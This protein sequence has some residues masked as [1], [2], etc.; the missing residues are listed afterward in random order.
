MT[1]EISPHSLAR[2]ARTQDYERFLAIQRAPAAKREA[3]YAITLLNAELARIGETVTEPMIRAIRFAWWREALEEL[4]A[5][6]HPRAHPILQVLSISCARQ[7]GLL[8]HLLSMC[9]ARG[10]W[11]EE[12]PAGA[13]RWHRYI[14]QTAGALH[15]AWA[16]LLSQQNPSPQ[17]RAI[18]LRAA[19][20][21]AVI[22]QL[23]SIPRACAAGYTPYPEGLMEGGGPAQLAE[24]G[25]L[26]DW[27]CRELKGLEM[28][29]MPGEAWQPLQV[30]ERISRLH[31]R[32]ILAANGN[33]Y[34]L[35][36]PR[37]RAV[38]CC[39]L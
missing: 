7:P 17:C 16:E 22:G 26:A 4:A 5:G 6:G 27:A 33:V 24:S 35:K 31:A 23:R 34:R 19:H 9:R 37:I 8:I 29:N 32:R 30:L 2:E 3:L 13:E 20:R 12:A 10:E 21:Y 25:V 15:L 18:I 39:L 1:G 38:L 28:V 14:E 11:W 36:Y